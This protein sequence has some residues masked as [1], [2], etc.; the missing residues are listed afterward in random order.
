MKKRKSIESPKHRREMDSNPSFKERWNALNRVSIEKTK[1]DKSLFSFKKE[2]EHSHVFDIPSH[3][4]QELLKESDMAQF[5]YLSTEMM[6]ELH[7]TQE[8]LSQIGD[9]SVIRRKI[10]LDLAKTKNYNQNIYYHATGGIG[11]TGVGEGLYLGK[12]KKALDNFYNC[13]G[14]EGEIIKY[15]G[16]PKWLNLTNYSDFE[17]FEQEAISCNGRRLN[18]EHLKL[19]T[20]SKGFEELDIMI[21]LQQ[22]KNSYCSEKPRCEWLTTQLRDPKLESEKKNFNCYSKQQGKLITNKSEEIYEKSS[23]L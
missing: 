9:L 5:K 16:S 22:E 11:E 8:R 13:D 1:A 21:P 20:L 15:I 4:D 3:F 14:T 17:T 10:R 7:E 19:Y 23:C 2:I 18:N 12:D 6:L